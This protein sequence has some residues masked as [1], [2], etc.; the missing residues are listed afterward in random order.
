MI[1]LCCDSLPIIQIMIDIITPTEAF[2]TM[3][4]LRVLAEII[5]NDEK[6]RVG[7]SVVDHEPIISQY[8]SV[9]LRPGF[10][11]ALQRAGRGGTCF[12]E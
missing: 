2:T 10:A 11:S 5:E 6:V 8:F 4:C 1:V 3:N 7:D 9:L 12:G